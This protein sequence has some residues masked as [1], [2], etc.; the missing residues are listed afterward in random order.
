MNRL[1]DANSRLHKLIADLEQTAF[2]YGANDCATFGGRVVQA[3]TGEDH[4]SAFVGKYKTKIGGFRQF[5][6]ATG[7]SS[8]IDWIKH[9]FEE[10]PVS[11]ARV[12]DL[13]LIETG[14]GLGVVVIAGAIAIGVSENGL[15]RIDLD[16]VSKAYKVGN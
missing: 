15:V 2:E 3:I 16:T 14:D 5:K 6:K 12:G 11:M 9:H 10:I 4:Y 13:G 7:F 8:H 1:P